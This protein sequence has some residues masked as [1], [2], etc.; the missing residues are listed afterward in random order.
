MVACVL[1]ACL[2]VVSFKDKAEDNAT[3]LLLAYHPASANW[4]E[5][6]TIGTTRGPSPLTGNTS[7]LSGPFN[8]EPSTKPS[9]AGPTAKPL[10][11]S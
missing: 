9:A 11:K 5:P 10:A 3:K 6:C 2:L 1:Q 4:V 7:F 8:C